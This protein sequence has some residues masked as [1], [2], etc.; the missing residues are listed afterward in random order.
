MTLKRTKCEFGG[1]NC[2]LGGIQP[3][4]GGINSKTRGK[5]LKSSGIQRKLAESIWKVNTSEVPEPNS[6]NNCGFT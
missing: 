4:V 1:I 6:K 3:K 5:D 2:E